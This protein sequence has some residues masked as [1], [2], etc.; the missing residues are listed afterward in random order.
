LYIIWLEGKVDEPSSFILQE[1]PR[2]PLI[3]QVT[4]PVHFE[5]TIAGKL[6]RD[7]RR[8]LPLLVLRLPDGARIGVVDRHH[9]VAPE[10]SGHK[11]TARLVFLLSNVTLQKDGAQRQGIVPETDDQNHVSTAPDMYGRV[12][13]VPTW[14]VRRGDLPYDVVYMEL[15]ID[16]GTGVVGL[17]T[18]VT[19]DDLAAKLGTD[20]FTKGDWVQVSRSRVDILG[21]DAV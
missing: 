9:V 16:V 13:A 20:Q 3:D 4:L 6:H 15:L 19:A 8:Y 11:G 7:G 2:F 12:V 1:M 10:L 17:R 18:N 14:E 21:F 5:R